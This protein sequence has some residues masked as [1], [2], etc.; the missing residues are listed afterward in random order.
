LSTMKQAFRSNRAKWPWT[1]TSETMSQKI[2]P[3]SLKLFLSG[4]CFRNK[5]LNN[6]G[7]QGDNR[8]WWG[9]WQTEELHSV[10]IRSLLNRSWLLVGGDLDSV[11]LN[12]LIFREKAKINLC[13]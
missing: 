6:T 7:Q 13:V 8:D 3:Y 11:W 4:I 9:L 12:L 1:K 10:S 5:S 2:N